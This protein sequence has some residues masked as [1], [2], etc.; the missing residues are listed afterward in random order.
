MLSLATQS[1]SEGKLNVYKKMTQSPNKY[2]FKPIESNNPPKLTLNALKANWDKF[3]SYCNTGYTEVHAMEDPSAINDIMK[4]FMDNHI[5][6]RTKKKLQE[7]KTVKELLQVLKDEELV[8][9]PTF[10]KTNL[11]S[12]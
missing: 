2:Q 9:W 3:M 5:L 8:F 6:P 1:K 7:A 10:I 4:A 11:K 12:G